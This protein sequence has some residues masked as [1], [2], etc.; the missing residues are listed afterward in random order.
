MISAGSAGD[1]MTA[2]VVVKTLNM[3][4][5][6]FNHLWSGYLGLELWRLGSDVD[7]FLDKAADIFQ[8]E[9]LLSWSSYIGFRNVD[10]GGS[11]D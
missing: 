11:F 10:I 8:T 2:S 3:I 4:R 1:G 6:S 5:M 9:L 7:C